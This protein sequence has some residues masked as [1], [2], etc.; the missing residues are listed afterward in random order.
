LFTSDGKGGYVKVDGKSLKRA[1]STAKDTRGYVQSGLVFRFVD[2][3][4]RASEKIRAAM[5][6]LLY[7]ADKDD[8][9]AYKYW[10]CVNACAQ[11][12]D[13][14]GFAL[15]SNYKKLTDIYFPY[16]MI[17]ALLEYGLT[18]EGQPIKLEII[19]T[20]AMSLERY[21]LD[22]IQ[23]EFNTFGRHFQRMLDGQ[24]AK[25]EEDPN[26]NKLLGGLLKFEFAWRKVLEARKPKRERKNREIAPPLVEAK[27]CKDY[28]LSVS[29]PSQGGMVLRQLWGAHSLFMLSQNSVNV[30][31]YLPGTLKPFPQTNPDFVTKV[32]SKVL[33]SP[34]VVKAIRFAQ[35]R[36]WEDLGAVDER[37]IYDMFRTHTKKYPNKYNI[38]VAGDADSC[39]VTIGRITVKG[40]VADWVLSKH[41]LMADYS[42]IVRFAG[43]IWKSPD[44]V[45]YVSGNSGTYRPTD[46]QVDAVVAFLRETFPHLRIEKASLS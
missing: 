15:N 4:E 32:K 44:G 42:P 18:F 7:T 22:I 9:E 39:N 40:M 8:P 6:E 24:R 33:F 31:A 43:E 14:A 30:E 27:Y 37:N 20:T 26:F 1:V 29:V 5:A 46:E 3:P 41:V 19:R 28:N 34:L 13:L 25:A 21:T 17:K 35:S 11:V 10:T 16:Q 2:L 36:N 12:L 45:I 38:V 23:A